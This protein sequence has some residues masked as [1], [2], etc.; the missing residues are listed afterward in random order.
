MSSST[1]DIIDLL[2]GIEPGSFLDRIRGERPET[3]LNVQKS[4]LALF[5]PVAEGDVT[6]AE[7]LAIA[8]FVTRL[9]R[10]ENAAEFYAAKLADVNGGAS[11]VASIS[12]EIEKGTAEG[13]Y[14]RYLAGPLS[15]EDVPGPTF[16]VSESSRA[17][18]GARLTAALEH[19]HLLVFRPREASPDALQKLIDSGW[20]ATGIVT[21]S[22]IVAFLSFQ[23]RVVAGL[24]ALGAA[25]EGSVARSAAE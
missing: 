5:E 19:A 21:L 7:R 10:A 13:P 3:R 18:L 9:H 15:A 6:R 22:Q 25:G 23:I 2:A 17:V 11:L 14:G 16:V 12:T 4:H 20:T 1:P 24:V 8:S